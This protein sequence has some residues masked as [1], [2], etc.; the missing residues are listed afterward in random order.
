M[1]TEDIKARIL[2]VK[3]NISNVVIGQSSAIDLVLVAL[4]SRG[5]VLLED[6]PGIGKTTLASSLAKSLDLE[7]NRIQFTPDVMPSDITGFNMYNPKDGEFHFH[8]GAIMANLVLADEI[9]RSSPKTQSSLLEAMQ[10]KQVTVDG[11]TYELPD[12]FIV[13]A[14]QNAV[15]QIGTYPLPEAQLDRFMIRTNLGYPSIQ[16]EMQIYD[17]H[18]GHSP[19]ETLESSLSQA[20]LK[21]IQEAVID[22][23][24]A[25]ALYEYVANISRAS[26][27]H[28]H[29][30][31]GVSPR[32]ALMLVQAAKGRAAMDGRDYVL[33]D[34]IK[35]LAPYTLAHRIILHN[36]AEFSNVNEI[37]VINDV[38]KEIPIPK[39][40]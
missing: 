6:V 37:S 35:F 4:I 15:E 7:F 38:L 22:V 5:H 32:G 27:D 3:N 1:N 14:T 34:D 23:Y 16:E 25:P 30:K 36:D 40:N 9:N 2:E 31:L 21:E 11:V 24:V 10:D 8:P 12:P 39:Q 29:V 13:I 28:R 18:A 17:K 26:R 33:P 19:L 20:E